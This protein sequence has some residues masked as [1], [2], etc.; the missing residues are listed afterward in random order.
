VFE[1]HHLADKQEK[2]DSRRNRKRREKEH[3]TYANNQVEERSC[4]ERIR[5]KSVMNCG[6]E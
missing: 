5:G 6:N 3:V 1:Y 2:G 4:Q